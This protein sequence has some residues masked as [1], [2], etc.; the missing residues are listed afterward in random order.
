MLNMG[1]CFKGKALRSAKGTTCLIY[2]GARTKRCTITHSQTQ[3]NLS[4]LVWIWQT[5]LNVPSIK[6]FTPC[7]FLQDEPTRLHM[8]TYEWYNC[9]LLY[10]YFGFSLHRLAKGRV[11][12]V[13]C[14]I[15]LHTKRLVSLLQT[16]YCDVSRTGWPV[17]KCSNPCMFWRTQSTSL[18]KSFPLYVWLSLCICC[19]QH[20]SHSLAAATAVSCQ[21]HTAAAAEDE[22][23]TVK[24][25]WAASVL[26]EGSM[27]RGVGF[28]F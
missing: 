24:P 26:A 18:W 2:Q 22:G 4:I 21:R 10:L 6:S 16:R 15:L 27:Q 5:E 11:L 3:L 14:T 7:A 25:C 28:F 20:Q 1:A 23:R 8:C 17:S 9:V 12:L 19:I 13:C